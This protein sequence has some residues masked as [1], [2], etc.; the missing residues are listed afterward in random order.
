MKYQEGY[1]QSHDIDWF[2]MA[3]GFPIHGASNAGYI[4]DVVNDS[5]VN[6]EIRSKLYGI[7][8]GYS[9][10]YN[11]DY[12]NELLKNQDD[13]AHEHYR[14]SFYDMACRGFYSFDCCPMKYLSNE[15]NGEEYESIYKLIA[16]PDCKI[17][18]DFSNL[19]LPNLCNDVKENFIIDE[20]TTMI[21]TRNG[22][23]HLI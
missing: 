4:P 19:M 12:I 10:R 16:W 11:E 18:P 6:R 14:S 8:S 7:P 17:L 21:V 5:Y 23:I 15:K 22:K 13:F 2:G 3:N 20:N 1:M 9:V